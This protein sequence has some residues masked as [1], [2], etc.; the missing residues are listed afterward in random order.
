MG[1]FGSFAL[2]LAPERVN[3]VGLY[4]RVLGPRSINN[5]MGVPRC[6]RIVEQEIVEQGRERKVRR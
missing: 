6:A 2:A 1:L 3:S 4:L 5:T